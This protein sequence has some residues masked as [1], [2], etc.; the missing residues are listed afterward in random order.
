MDV[1][2]EG[3]KRH[4]LIIMEHDTTSQMS[5]VDDAAPEIL[6]QTQTAVDLENG[7]ATTRKTS[8]FKEPQYDKRDSHS[9]N[10]VWWDGP[11]D[12]SNPRNW[13]NSKK[14]TNVALVS[15]QCLISPIASAM[16]AP[17]VQRVME[18][19]NSTSKELATF[20][21]SVFV[22][23]FGIGPL[24]LAPLSE[25]YGRLPIYLWTNIFFVIFTIACAVS[26]NLNMLVGFRFL[27]G[28]AGSAPLANG[29]GTIADLIIQEKRGAAMAI[30]GIGPLLG[31]VI[32]PIAG[33][34]LAEAEGWRWVFWVIAIAV[35]SSL[36]LSGTMLY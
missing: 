36:L 10:E 26:T 27:A 4:Q 13:P 14:F 7:L 31:P 15:L 23:G 16:F 29:G 6:E 22:L 33:G 30:F 11:D 24:V 1:V 8:N 5:S 34:Y 25:I 35:S 28:L 19:F 17:G 12:P 21:V 2:L 20:V 3:L 18:D 9:V 32:G